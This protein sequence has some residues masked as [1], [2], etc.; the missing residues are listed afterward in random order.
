MGTHHQEVSRWQHTELV[1]TLD[2][3]RVLWARQDRT[4]CGGNDRS[5][6]LARSHHLVSGNQPPCESSVPGDRTPGGSGELGRGD[7]AVRA[8]H[9]GGAESTFRS[10]R[11]LRWSQY[12]V[13]SDRAIR[14]HWQLVCCAFSFCWYH[15]SHPCSGRAEDAR[16]ASEPPASQ[17]L[18][19]AVDVTAPGKKK[20]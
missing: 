9:V 1:G 15:A 16:E 6:D 13:R 14:R 12:Q 20:P 4:G 7:Q 3:S 17:E 10:N 5:A 2:R 8:A 18:G 11:R 19:G